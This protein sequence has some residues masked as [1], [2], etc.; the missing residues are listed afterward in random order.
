MHRK[1]NATSNE[2]VQTHID[3]FS[4]ELA[5]LRSFLEFRRGLLAGDSQQDPLKGKGLC[6]DVQE[7]IDTAQSMAISL[8]NHPS[9]SLRI[10]SKTIIKGH[11]PALAIQTTSPHKVAVNS[12]LAPRHSPNVEELP[13]SHISKPFIPNPSP[14]FY[15]EVND[16]EPQYEEKFPPAVYTELINTLSQEV[17]RHMRAGNFD[18]AE[19]AQIKAINHYE[20]REKHW[21]ITY[22]C[23]NQMDETLVEIFVRGG[24]LGAAQNL[25]GKLLEEETTDSPRKLQLYHL[26]AEV[27]LGQAQLEEA[28]KFAKRAYIG[29]E[30]SLG[31]GHGLILASA[32]LLIRIYDQKGEPEAA[33]AF[34]NLY[35]STV[36]AHV[37][38]QVSKHVGKMRVAWNPD[39]SVNINQVNHAGKT[40]LVMAVIAG[41]QEAL[42]AA[43]REGAD[44][45]ARGRDG[46]SP[47]MHAVTRGHGKI[48]EVLVSRGAHVDATTADWTPLHKAV[49]TGDSDMIKLLIAGGADIEFNSPERY[50]VKDTFHARTNSRG[51]GLSDDLDD[52]DD[53][54]IVRGWTPLHRA[55]HMGRGHVV[56]L[57]L[58]HRADIEALD[59]S[60]ATPLISAAEEQNENII[61]LLLVRG[62]NV[63][64]EDEFGWKPLHRATANKGG[65][66]VAQLL[67]NHGADVNARCRQRKT[68]L[69]HAV[70]K[71]D[72]AMVSFLLRS[73]ADIEARDVAERTP[74]HT[75]IECRLERMVVLLLGFGADATAQDK[76][77]RDAL[78]LAQRTPRRSP[79]I[80]KLLQK[81]KQLQRNG[82]MTST[83]GRVDRFPRAQS[84]SASFSTA[85]TIVATGSVDAASSEALS[86]ARAYGGS[87]P[88]TPGKESASWWR[89][90][91][92]KMRKDR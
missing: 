60:Q 9:K 26:L 31:K 12:S 81:Q 37:W 57:L 4:R 41:D 25:L 52:S 69:H 73:G 68:P 13:D 91:S 51:S 49:E 40:Q 54:D 32:K 80:V 58:D 84:P 43:L 20:D 78:T 89:R 53:I 74:L 47:L 36:H 86:V 10:D 55:C 63:A 29:R 67:L 59:P 66:Q 19:I 46:V 72:N 56:R 7:C 38:P 82:S 77:G 14:A 27:Y 24:R 6:D 88:V 45:E 1:Q 85:G 23:R 42:Q 87:S 22:G 71:D 17:G 30:K 11:D 15:K 33:Q 2:P 83:H 79:E 62:A 50:A 75:A 76:A 8:D 5:E 16:P 34:R 3:A 64:A 35:D 90:S 39:L 70:A 65:V 44:L 28:E 61:D 92:K 18:R 48:A 21:N